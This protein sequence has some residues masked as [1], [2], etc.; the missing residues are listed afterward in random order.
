MLI[1][2][3]IAL[4][5][6]ISAAA[7]D[8]IETRR[9]VVAGKSTEANTWLVGPKPTYKALLLRELLQSGILI[10]CGV[11]GF[12]FASPLVFASINGM[13]VFGIK[14]IRGGRAWTKL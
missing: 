5:F 2:F 13:V 14:H 12:M 1:A 3:V 9:G 4:I 11:L 6:L 7:F 10:V 8:M